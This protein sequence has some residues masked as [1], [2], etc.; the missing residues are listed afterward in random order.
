M[1]IW[2]YMYTWTWGYMYMWIPG[3]KDMWIHEYMNMRIEGDVNTCTVSTL[4]TH[5]PQWTAQ[6]MGFQ[7]LWVAGGGENKCSWKSWKFEKFY[8]FLHNKSTHLESKQSMPCQQVIIDTFLSS[9]VSVMIEQRLIWGGQA[10]WADS[11]LWSIQWP[12]GQ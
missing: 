3:Y 12:V 9:S 10:L 1:R 7:G 6:A 8:F 4:I 11:G 2:G 5:T